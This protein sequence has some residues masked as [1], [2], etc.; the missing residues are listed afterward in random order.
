MQEVQF[1]G[2]NITI[3]E[4]TKDFIREKLAKHTDLLKKATKIHVLIKQNST[5]HDTVRNYRVEIS[6][7]M[8]HAFIRV[9]EKGT[10]LKNIVDKADDVLRRRLKRY[11]EQ[12]HK[13]E[14]EKPWIAEMVEGDVDEEIKVETDDYLD[15]QPKIKRKTY[16]DDT[17]LHPAKAIE[18]MELIGHN[19]FIFKNIETDK[20]TMIYRRDKGGYGMIEPPN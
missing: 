2:K 12:N 11:H 1:T 20:Y 15:Y 8:K 16:E 18:R 4:A 3:S 7:S 9:E 13:W 6:I 10:E 19:S 5:D 17:P 14:A